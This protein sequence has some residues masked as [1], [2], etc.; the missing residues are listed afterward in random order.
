MPQALSK[1]S[2][3]DL[4][5]DASLRFAFAAMLVCQIPGFVQFV[6]AHTDD[7]ARQVVEPEVGF[8][9]RRV[10]VITILCGVVTVLPAEL[11]LGAALVIIQAVLALSEILQRGD[12][13]W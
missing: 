7:S 5:A 11:A 1:R 12:R 2:I 6:H 13:N 8:V 4:A 10:A 3:W 9:L